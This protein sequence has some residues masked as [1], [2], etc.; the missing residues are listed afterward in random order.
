VTL[1]DVFLTVLYAR[2]GA[3]IISLRLAC[4]VWWIFR[5]IARPI[6]RYR[7]VIL[8]Y[9][10][11][12]ILVLLVFTWL[13]LLMLGGAMIFYPQLGTGVQ[14]NQ[15]PTPTGF[16]TALYVAGDAVTTVGASDIS[17]KTPVL[18]LLYT[19]MSIIG[20]STLTLTLTYFLEV[21]SMLQKRNTYVMKTH[22]ATGDS[23]DAVELLAGLGPTGEFSHG[24]SQL[25][26]MAAESA[27]LYE[28]H[29]FYAVLLYFRFREPHYA[30]SRAALVTLDAIT[31][32]KSA[33]D[34]DRYAW[35]KESAA[36]TQIW[37][38]VMRI[39]TE[40]SIVFLPGGLPQDTPDPHMISLWRQRYRAALVR[41]REAGISTIADEQAGA[42][43][44]V[45]LRARWDRYIRAFA[46]HMVHPMDQI[47]PAGTDPKITLERPE[48]SERLHTVG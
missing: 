5:K 3:G 35:L 45:S 44:Y 6:A 28:A 26:E 22:H 31:L 9:C 11:P 38:A 25:A 36:V 16:A 34:D 13:I 43:V 1:L 20:I 47:D 40:L 37:R 8:S 17:P 27:E 29:H 15:G 18:R 46:E 30:L 21:Y 48:F 12:S 19:F 42:E 32:I 4:V 41:L 7:D 14:A 39:V 23:G 24:Y 10:G 2:M 33:L